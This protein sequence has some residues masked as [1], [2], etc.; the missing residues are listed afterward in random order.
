M[1]VDLVNWPWIPVHN[2]R[3]PLSQIPLQ[4]RSVTRCIVDTG[5]T[6]EFG[7]QPGS[8]LLR[9]GG[10][11]QLKSEEAV[12]AL[13]GGVT[14]GL[15]PALTLFGR[16]IE[17]SVVDSTGELVILFSG[18]VTARISASD[19]FESWELVMENGYRAICGA[20]GNLTVWSSDAGPAET[21]MQ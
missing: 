20:R 15:G 4:G 1:Q 21:R 3:P 13:H 2:K 14:S 6:L 7:T 17:S 5:F 10:P 11:F 12:F 9:I 16:S 8:C 19:L 18:D